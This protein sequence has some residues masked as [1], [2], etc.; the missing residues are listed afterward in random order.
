VR[1]LGGETPPAVSGDT[2]R[3]W[4][5]GRGVCDAFGRAF[6]FPPV[7]EHFEAPGP[8]LV[9]I[10]VNAQGANEPDDQHEHGLHGFWWGCSGEEGLVTQRYLGE[11]YLILAAL[12]CDVVHDK[13]RTTVGKCRVKRGVVAYMGSLEGAIEYMS[14]RW[15]KDAGPVPDWRADPHLFPPRATWIGRHD[16]PPPPGKVYWKRNHQGHWYPAW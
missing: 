11:D 15:P 2:S 16:P 13:H 9:A 8:E 4:I 6:Q 5:H 14:E 12:E 7:G 3:G 1:P 10:R